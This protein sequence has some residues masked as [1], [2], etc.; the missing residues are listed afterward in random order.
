M[1][2]WWDVHVRRDARRNNLSLLKLGVH[3]ALQKLED[4]CSIRMLLANICANGVQCPG[5]HNHSA[6]R[7]KC[8]VAFDHL[9]GEP[10]AIIQELFQLVRVNG[11][12][13]HVMMANAK[14]THGSLEAVADC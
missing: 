6:K 9:L 10:H 13:G 1:I 5:G 14:V 8:P 4:R 11:E 2:L 3:G 12:C 7:M